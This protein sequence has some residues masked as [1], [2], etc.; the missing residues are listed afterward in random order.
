M[1]TPTKVFFTKGVGRHKDY[2]QSFE[3]ALRS[4]GIEKC[5]IVTVSSIYPPGC[6]RISREE[7][8]KL[9]HPGS[10]TFAV[11]A[12]NSTNEPNRLIAA[13]LGVAQPADENMY[14]YLSEHH[15]FG[16]TDEKAGDYAEDLAATMLATTLGLEFD[17]NTA[18][19]E[20]EKLYK[21]SGKIV[22]TFNV[23]QSAEGDKN[24][25]WTTV[26]AVA[27]LLP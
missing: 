14:G 17:P 10:I 26:I 2:L 27:V 19:D 20:R 16:E 3:L 11:M 18:W 22:R 7:G 9:L 6:K 4:A 24:G 13:S 15:P 12:R 25:L 23:T 5:N 8:L 21:M 1:F